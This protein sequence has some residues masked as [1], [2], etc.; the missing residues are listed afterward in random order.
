MATPPDP[1]TG[2]DF[3]GRYLTLPGPRPV[4]GR[5]AGGGAAAGLSHKIDRFGLNVHT[6]EYEPAA[7]PLVAEARLGWVRLAAWWRLMERRRGEIDFSQLDL[8]VQAAVALGLKVMIVFASIPGWANGTSPDL[9]IIDR[10]GTLPPTDPQFFRDFVTAVVARFRGRVSGYEIW[11]EPNYKVFWNGDYGRFIDE[12]LISGARAVKAADPA[13]KTLGPATHWTSTM[14]ATAVIKACRDLDV[15]TCH[16]YV[17][18]AAALFQQMDDLYRPI[19]EKR[20]NKPL[21][22]TEFGIDSWVT[23]DDFQAKELVAA[24]DGL[25]QRA[26]LERLFLFDWRDGDWPYPYQKG[27]GLVTN[28]LEGLRRKKAFWAVQDL[29]LQWLGLPGLAS[30]PQPADGATNVPRAAPL[31]WH[32]GRKARSHRISLGLGSPVFQRE[33]TETTFPAS[34]AQREYGRTYVWRVDEVGGGGSPQGML[35]QFTVEEDPASPGTPVIVR[36]AESHPYFLSV[37][38]GQGHAECVPARSL[39]IPGTPEEMAKGAWTAAAPATGPTDLTFLRPVG[40]GVPDPL[41]IVLS[42]LRPGKPYRVFGR[43][44]TT[45]EQA[46]RQAGIRMGL[47]PSSMV[48][49]RASTPGAKVVRQEGRWE[50]REVQI[51]SARAQGGSLQVVL[52]GTGA[53]EYATWSGLRLELANGPA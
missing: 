51:G 6:F 5:V 38:Q 12:I 31:A 45:R 28:G 40:K 4:L 10:K 15:L 25:R 35:W 3:A 50:E 19:L 43:F 20:C 49:Y 14:F 23:G 34:A 18:S 21:W 47:A 48:L 13:A 44:V 37:V 46:A 32:A 33:Q 9:G 8:S 36:I 22:V 11:N 39:V 17:G 24:L 7:F 41:T 16:L 2:E 1:S 42:G 30:A 26:Y 27:L 53:E 52:D 29:A